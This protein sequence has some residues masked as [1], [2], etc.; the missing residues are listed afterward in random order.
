M[1]GDLFQLLRRKG[2]LDKALVIA[3]S[4]DGEALGLPT[5]TVSG[6][7]D[8]AFVQALRE[9]IGMNDHGHG[10]SELSP[11]QYKVLLGLRSFDPVANFRSSIRDLDAPI[12]A[13]DIGPAILELVG[14]SGDPL[15]RTGQSFALLLDRR[16][17]GLV[18]ILAARVGFTENDLAALPGP[19]GGVDEL[20]TARHKAMF[21][22]VDQISGRLELNE[23]YALLATSLNERAAFIATR[24]LLAPLP[25]GPHEHQC[26]FFDLEKGQ[27]RLF[28]ERPGSDVTD[29]ANL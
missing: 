18:E 28:L 10:Q 21:F 22:N 7:Y 26:I 24:G 15:G 25:A 13:E 11:S 19:G 29:A 5:D 27:E 4:D 6:E 9:P 3:F 12:T 14:V 23:G 16:D 17:G 20:A 8:A 1:F 2:A